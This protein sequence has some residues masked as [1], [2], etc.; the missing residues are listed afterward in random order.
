MAENT[1]QR[2]VWVDGTGSGFRVDV[3]VGPF[4]LVGDAGPEY[5]GKD[6]GPN[7]YDYL[8]ISL[9]TCTA[10]TVNEYATSMKMP[11]EHVRV[12]LTHKSIYPRDCKDCHTK[13]GVIEELTTE[14]AVTGPITDDQ[15]R[16]LLEA[17]EK[18]PVAKILTN[19]IKI[20][21]KLVTGPGAHASLG[22][23]ASEARTTPTA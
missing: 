4:T 23:P 17:I 2:T 19:E 18:C 22:A 5:G 8:L 1:L 20:R 16:V 12:K 21:N 9:G 10:M 13:D 6:T 3:K 7:P 14:I 15:K 11:V